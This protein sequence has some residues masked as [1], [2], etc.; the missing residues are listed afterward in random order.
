M[1]LMKV[2]ESGRS[3]V[4]LI[5]SILVGI[6]LGSGPL[7]SSITNRYGC[8]TATIIGAIVASIGFAV[9]AAAP[10]I[11]M[12][13]VTIG[14]CTGLGFGLI[15]LPAIV[16]VSMY[17]EKRRAFA[18][19]IAVCGSGLGTFIMAPVTEGLIDKL[20]FRGAFLVTA[21]IVLTNI[22]FGALFRPLESPKPITSTCSTTSGP[23]PELEDPMLEKKN[24]FHFNL[25]N[26][27]ANESF[28]S[29]DSA[30][31]PG[32]PPVSHDLDQDLYKKSI[33]PISRR[34]R[35]MGNPSDPLRSR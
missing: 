30:I 26:V 27:P 35:S 31:V 3:T 4:S 28:A 20:G 17:F 21:A 34:S 29:E 23:D 13:Y 7:A 19:G 2:F 32:I 24:S 22:L 8:R 6:T 18:T 1:E 25:P 11:V 10:N 14:L 16:S 15:Y 9:S 12:L 33:N 5:P